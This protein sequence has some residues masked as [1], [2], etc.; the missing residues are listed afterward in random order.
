MKFSCCYLGI[1]LAS[2]CLGVVKSQYD[3]EGL[4]RKIKEL[5]EDFLGQNSM[6][7]HLDQLSYSEQILVGNTVLEQLV[8]NLQNKFQKRILTVQQLQQAVERAYSGITS[9]SY[10]CCKFPTSQ[11]E[12][13]LRFKNKVAV[14]QVCEQISPEAESSL[15]RL[16]PSFVESCAQNLVELPSLKWQYFGSEQGVTTIFPALISDSCD[17]YDNRFR[18]WYVQANVPVPKEVVVVIDKSGSMGRRHGSVTLM[19]L[20]KS[21]AK[22]VISTLNPFDKF[23]V[24]AFSTNAQPTNVGD[25]ANDDC[26]SSTLAFATPGNIKKVSGFIDSLIA[27]GSTYYAKALDKAFNFF[28][29][30]VESRN[31]TKLDRVILFMS[32]GQPSE[33]STSTIFDTLRSRNA[34]VNNSVVILTY[35]L[36]SSDFDVLEDMATATSSVIDE[37]DIRPGVFTQ[38]D[39]PDLLRNQMASYYNFFKV[40]NE[41]ASDPVWTVPYL[42]AWG[43]GVM[44]TASLPVYVRSNLI[45]VAAVDVTI[46]ELFAETT[47]IVPGELSYSFVVNEAGLMIDHP[48]FPQIGIS[49]PLFASATAFERDPEFVEIFESMKRGES[50]EKTFYSTKVLSGGDGRRYGAKEIQVRSTYFWKKIPGTDFSVCLVLANEDIQSV[51]A[52]QGSVPRGSFLYHRLDLVPPNTACRHLN[53]YCSMDQSS[54]FLASRSYEDPEYYLSRVFTAADVSRIKDYMEGSTTISQGLKVGIKD[55]VVATSY[56]GRWWTELHNNTDIEEEVVWRYIG[57]KNGVFRHFPGTRYPDDYDP[58]LRP[59]YEH[60]LANRGNNVL[61]LPYKD[62]ASGAT[63]ITLSRVLFEGKFGGLHDVINDEVVA[64]MGVDILLSYFQT[65]L[66]EFF[67]DCLNDD[68]TRCVLMDKAGFVIFAKEYLESSSVRTNQH[69]TEVDSNIANLLIRDGIL[70]PISCSNVE[71]SLL[72]RTYNV[73]YSGSYSVTI[74]FGSNCETIR[75]IPIEQTNTYMVIKGPR[76]SGGSCSF[77]RPLKCTCGSGIGTVCET[78]WSGY[79]CECPCQSP[80]PQYHPCTNE[81]DFSSSRVPLCSPENKE[82]TSVAA[83]NTDLSSL[84]ICYKIAFTFNET[85]NKE[86]TSVAATNTDLSSLPICYKIAFTFDPTDSGQSQG[87]GLGA[88]VG[89]VVGVVAVVIVGIIIAI[90]AKKSKPPRNTRRTSQPSAPPAYPAQPAQ[91]ATNPAYFAAEEPSAIYVNTVEKGAYP[92]NNFPPSYEESSRVN[93]QKY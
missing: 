67:P 54:V 36:G 38:V 93:Y 3:S 56:A 25:T 78:A 63:I 1:F 43:L 91:P 32:D 10:E 62:A 39:N 22:T 50:G 41:L 59:W 73:S 9:T 92:A 55:E 5:V 21:A 15:V 57:T 30:D 8:N 40:E 88:I 46:E 2:F 58:V 47:N 20:A 4:S 17:D 83:T 64:V 16:R 87:L 74:N 14:N 69:L 49:E 90:K 84:P 7:K 13:D 31:S 85:E 6:Q 24:V 86:L 27:D 11:T 48:L 66:A 89:I 19:E 82:L 28:S 44:I 80:D 37:S 77:Y 51:L 60:A 29:T 33:P 71:A 53:N 42:D 65:V 68:S 61:T 70:N 12:Y 52:P 23:T 35:G 18:P 34:E 79:A 26:F 76:T 45:G 72:Q 81:Y 75:V